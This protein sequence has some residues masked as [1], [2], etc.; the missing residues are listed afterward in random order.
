MGKSVFEN[1]DTREEWSRLRAAIKT[2][3]FAEF[4]VCKESN[5][6]QSTVSGWNNGRSPTIRKLNDMKNGLKRLID[7]RNQDIK[8]IK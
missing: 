8:N 6:N 5:T 4:E 7:K 2:A 3:G 1:I